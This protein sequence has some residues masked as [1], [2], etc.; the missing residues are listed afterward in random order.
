MLR[1]LFNFLINGLAVFVSGY[2]LPGVYTENYWV[3]LLTAFVIGLLNLFV[4][5]VLLFFSL[6]ITVVTFGLFT[7][8]I[9]A[10]VILLASY[11][12]SG[13]AVEDFLSALLFALVLA[14]VTYVFRL[15]LGAK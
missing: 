1:P 8:V 9:D 6:P 7:L 5:P 10:V 12:V 3:A 11:F 13:F 4:K 14:F 15:L 2:F